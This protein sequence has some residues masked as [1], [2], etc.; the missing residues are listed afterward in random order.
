MIATKL[1]IDLI[2]VMQNDVIRV[3]VKTSV[4]SDDVQIAESFEHRVI[5]PGNDYSGEDAKVQAIAA[6]VHTAGVIAAYK[7]AQDTQGV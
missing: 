5:A 4:L 7:A 1:T 2:E 3:R 6:A